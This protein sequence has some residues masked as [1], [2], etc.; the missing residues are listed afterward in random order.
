MKPKEN[1]QPFLTVAA[2]QEQ[3]YP[4]GKKEMEGEMNR[5]PLLGNRALDRDSGPGQDEL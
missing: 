4:Q 1:S 3:G 2:S 5:G